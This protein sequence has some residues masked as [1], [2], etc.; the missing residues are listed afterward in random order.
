MTEIDTQ[1]S[2][3]TSS[4]QA[5]HSY[6]WLKNYPEGIDYFSD[7][8]AKPLTDVFDEA[9]SKYKDLPL[10][11]F[12]GKDYS[13]GETEKLVQ[14]AAI[15]L[16]KLGVVK[17]TKVGLCLPNT[18]YSVIFY[19]AV[20]RAG[21][22]VVNY[23]PLYAEKEL[24][25]QI[26]DSDTEIMVTVDLAAVYDKF[27]DLLPRVKIKKVV[28]C[29]FQDI[30]PF[31]KSFL[32]P[33][34]KASMKASWEKD[35]QH[36]TY[37]QLMAASGGLQR[38]EIDPETD[39]A[40]LQYTG[41]T[42]GV[43]KGA[44]LSHANLYLNTVQA[45]LWLGADAVRGGETMMAILP[46]FHV[47]AMTVCL[48]MSLV[49]GA[50]ILLQPKFD[51]EEVMKLIPKD[52]PTIFPAVPTIYN[53][54]LNH[55]DVNKVDLSSF[56]VCISGGA[57]LPVEVKHAFEKVSGCHLVEGYG[58]TETSPIA[59]ANPLKGVNKPGSIGLPM[60]QTQVSIISLEDG[61]TE[62]P[63][64]EKGEICIT[65][66]QVMLGYYKR[67]AD[68]KENIRNGRF[69]T[70]DVGYMDEDGHTFIVDRIKDMILCSGFNVYP[71][72]VEE[73]IYE[74]QAVAECIVLGLPDDY[75]G[76]TVKA[77]VKL[78]DGYTD[79]PYEELKEFLRERLS[80]IEMPKALEI[81]TELPKTMIGKL[82]RKDLLEEELQ[83]MGQA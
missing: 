34:L 38:Y 24:E 52:R 59:V 78:A 44:M 36:I 76:Q 42:T 39:V 23:N 17:G 51:I 31:P 43:P 66:P 46:F 45:E 1:N 14:Q 5:S 56:K 26:N 54:I 63:I 50:K 7:M 9:V 40:V 49:L 11:D 67:E 15:G 10:M 74:H 83:K 3:K 29:R 65:G 33:I 12:M 71:R 69:H 18:P 22:V 81:R 47:F 53:A 80:P 6:P 4:E 72:N 28:M 64:G 48:N 77:Y 73:A 57:P 70:G 27:K 82:S 55:K 19:Y 16:Q 32:F 21:G 68:T 61:K 79:L 30:L 20:L 62:M 2:P 58:L 41:G 35:E 8:T 75:R 60:P 25:H 37:Q 13:Y